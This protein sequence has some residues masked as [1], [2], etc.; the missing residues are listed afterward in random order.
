MGFDLAAGEAPAY[1]ARLMDS[2]GRM[3][4]LS[5]LCAGLGPLW[6]GIALAARRGHVGHVLFVVAVCVAAVA[7]SSRIARVI[8]VCAPVAVWHLAAAMQRPNQSEQD[9]L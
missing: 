3:L 7:L 2:D 1:A 6:V 4:V 5:R 9:G 8:V